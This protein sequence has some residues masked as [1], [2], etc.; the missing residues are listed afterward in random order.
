ML[1]LHL[2]DQQFYCLLG[3]ILY[4]YI[5]RNNIGIPILIDA[6]GNTPTSRCWVSRHDSTDYNTMTSSYRQYFCMYFVWHGRKH[7]RLC[8][9]HCAC[10]WLSNVRWLKFQSHIYMSLRRINRPGS[11]SVQEKWFLGRYHLLNECL[12]IISYTCKISLNVHTVTYNLVL[13]NGNICQ[14]HNELTWWQS[15]IAWKSQ[16][17]NQCLK[18]T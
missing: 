8:G 2:N 9:Q 6:E 12:L 16:S 11:S 17:H 5:I 1:Q 14:G 13:E 10:W 15:E 3:C 7:V 4:M 18:P